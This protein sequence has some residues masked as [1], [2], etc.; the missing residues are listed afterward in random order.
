[1]KK[2]KEYRG[3]WCGLPAT[4]ISRFM[5]VSLSKTK[6]YLYSAL[7]VFG[8]RFLKDDELLGSLIQEVRN[9]EELKRIRSCIYDR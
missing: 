9:K 7:E 5:G 8:D 6:R 1:M 3:K 2:R 4:K